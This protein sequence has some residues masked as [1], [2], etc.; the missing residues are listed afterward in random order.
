MNP[1][2]LPNPRRSCLFSYIVAFSINNEK[3]KSMWYLLFISIWTGEDWMETKTD[4]WVKWKTSS[5]SLNIYYTFYA[6]SSQFVKF[7]VTFTFLEQGFIELN[8][9]RDFFGSPW[10]S[11]IN[12]LCAIW[13]MS[14]NLLLILLLHVFLKLR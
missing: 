3:W 7:N 8:E 11:K 9:K 2:I 1:F 12:V 4:D 14:Y 13:V 5:L 6:S 10:I